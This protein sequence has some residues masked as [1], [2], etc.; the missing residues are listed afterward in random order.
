M[1]SDEKRTIFSRMRFQRGFLGG[2]AGPWVHVREHGKEVEERAG[3][4]G[5]DEKQTAGE[6]GQAPPLGVL[7]VVALKSD[8][9]VELLEEALWRFRH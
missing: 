9:G 1:P 8:L 3:G 7:A 4:G 5:H 6:H 2:G